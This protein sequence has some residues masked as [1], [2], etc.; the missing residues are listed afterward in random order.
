MTKTMNNESSNNKPFDCFAFISYK[1]EDE[2]WA[3]WLQ[4][5]LESY[6]LP[7]AIRKNNPE[8]P[9]KIR[10]VFRDQSELSGGN[11][12]TEIEKGLN[13]SKYLIVICSPRSAQSPWVSKE[14][15]HFIDKGR[16]EYIIPFII[17]GTPN[18]ANPEDECFPEGLRQLTGE[19]EILGININEMGRDAAT[20]KVIARMFNLRFDSLW[21]RFEKEKRNKRA[22]IGF[23]A[24]ITI[25][26]SISSAVHIARK[27]A[28]LKDA[29]AAII[30]ER[31]RAN[32]EWNRANE[33][34]LLAQQERDNALDA[35]NKLMI[36]YDSITKQAS[37]IVQ[38]NND[39]K[40][41]QARI[42]DAQAT[43]VG[44]YALSLLE[45]GE[46]TDARIQINNFVSA[47]YSKIK[48]NHRLERAMRQ[49][50][51]L[52]DGVD[53]RLYDKIKIRPIEDFAYNTNSRILNTT[54]DA[55][56]IDYDNRLYE[57]RLDNNTFIELYD[58]WSIF[59]DMSGGFEA[60]VPN[61]KKAYI[62]L[63]DG[64]LAALNLS[65]KSY[66]TFPDF[67]YVTVSLNPK[68][69]LALLDKDLDPGVVLWDVSNDSIIA[70]IDYG[71]GE[72][73]FVAND[74]MEFNPSPSH[75][76]DRI[77]YEVPSFKILPN[78]NEAAYFTELYSQNIGSKTYTFDLNN[79]SNELF[80]YLNNSDSIDIVK[81]SYENLS[82]T[83]KRINSNDKI[84]GL[85]PDGVMPW[86]INI[87]D[88]GEY[89]IVNGTRMIHYIVDLA[90]KKVIK[91]ISGIGGFDGFEVESII[92]HPLHN[93]LLL[94]I[95]GDKEMPNKIMVFT[96][97]NGEICLSFESKSPVYSFSRN[98][99]SIIFTNGESIKFPHYNMLLK[100][101]YA[102]SPN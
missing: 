28:M 85:I 66:S 87:S 42:I 52:Y 89:A 97:E 49:L 95:R 63:Q 31:D 86:E 47:N 51:F 75:Q 44:E 72:Y 67:S 23:C 8:L 13:G 16:E 39:L 53:K 77:Y 68:G 81:P 45:K 18:A 7:T 10:P 92:W 88:N 20:I 38:Q 64:T 46:P 99:D 29:N 9:N 40:E 15:Q 60:Y 34:T 25:L 102:P 35:N 79:S 12:K 26:L 73:R 36:A 78:F 33:Q 14:V 101:F 50:Y 94:N 41:S 71:Y 5:K 91:R 84:A 24:I 62:T 1:R 56:Y 17:G 21:Q 19:I 98:G 58:G 100:Y 82:N 32:N 59:N 54:P 30:A 76:G 57:Y 43:I 83:F 27:N 22:I 90:H 37:L 70:S 65:D 6:S 80:V 11:L 3:K 4:K 74:I 2:K 48:Y 69:S 55:V 61:L 93:K 96:I